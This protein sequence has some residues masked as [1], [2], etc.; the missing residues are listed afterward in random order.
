MA[1]VLT[2][3]AG[4]DPILKVAGLK[5]GERVFKGAMQQDMGGSSSFHLR[6]AGG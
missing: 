3:L 6:L 1:A 5:W 4:S 2:T